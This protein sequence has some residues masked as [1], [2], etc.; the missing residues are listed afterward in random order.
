[1][2]KPGPL[3]NRA[4]VRGTDRCEPMDARRVCGAPD[5]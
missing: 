5:D 2:G 3:T 4:A 1:M